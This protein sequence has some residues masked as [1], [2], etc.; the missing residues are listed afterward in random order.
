VTVKN[1]FVDLKNEKI[2]IESNED[3]CKKGDS[4]NYW[5]Q[6]LMDFYIQH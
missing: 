6:T 3:F 5:M 1:Y 2:K 4:S